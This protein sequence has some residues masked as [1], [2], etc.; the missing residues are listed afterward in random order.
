MPSR[1][2]LWVRVVPLPGN[3]QLQT[4]LEAIMDRM[5]DF[6]PVWPAIAEVFYTAEHARFSAEGPGWRA[7][8]DSTIQTRLALGYGAGPIMARTMTL[9]QS[10]IQ[11]GGAGSVYVPLPQSVEMGTDVAYS[12]F[13]QAGMGKNP[14]RVLLQTAPMVKPW[15]S[16]LRK[17]LFSRA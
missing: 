15:M 7:L 1:T 17:Y 16:I 5:K 10:L 3:E 6:Q 13:H 4:Q 2:G 14:T 12:K 11:Q 9:W 8:A